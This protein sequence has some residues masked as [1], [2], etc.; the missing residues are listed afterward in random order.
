MPLALILFSPGGRLLAKEKIAAA[1]GASE[2]GW[3]DTKLDADEEVDN[4][5]DDDKSDESTEPEKFNKDP[6]DSYVDASTDEDNWM[7]SKFKE[8]REEEGLDTD[9]SD[10]VQT[11]GSTQ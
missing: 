4:A 10:E 2:D 3:G 9:D 8:D 6:D 7:K 11:G 5:W 1:Y